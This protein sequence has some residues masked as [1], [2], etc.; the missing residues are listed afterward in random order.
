MEIIF[1]GKKGKE[2]TAKKVS[3]NTV[4]N[5]SHIFVGLYTD[6]NYDNLRYYWNN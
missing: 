6:F 1:K 5:V 2:T 3:S 4:F